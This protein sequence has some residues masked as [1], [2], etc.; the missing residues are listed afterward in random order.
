M[1]LLLE[2]SPTCRSDVAW[3][4]N[5]GW[6]PRTAPGDLDLRT[7][8]VPLWGTCDVKA[9]LFNSDEVLQNRRKPQY[10]APIST[11]SIYLASRSTR[12]DSRGERI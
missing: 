11:A 3:E 9:D 1:W 6:V 5:F 2:K 8:N 12:R 4:R 10:K 7:R